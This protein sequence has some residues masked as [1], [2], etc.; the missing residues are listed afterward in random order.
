MKGTWWIISRRIEPFGVV[1]L[2]ILAVAMP[3]LYFVN[4]WKMESERNR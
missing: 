2:V 1:L 3:V 4:G